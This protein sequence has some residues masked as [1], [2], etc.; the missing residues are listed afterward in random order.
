MRVTFRAFNR[1]TQKYMKTKDINLLGDGTV[2]FWNGEDW[3]LDHD[4]IL[5]IQLDVSIELP[6]HHAS[7][8]IT[9]N[10]FTT[11]YEEPEDW[12][13]GIVTHACGHEDQ[14]VEGE[15]EKAFE[16]RSI[17]EVQWYPDTPIGSYTVYASTLEKALSKAVEIQRK[18]DEVRT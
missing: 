15:M 13:Q 17:W 8:N 18:Q 3:Q 12:W 11:S 10:D 4:E 5:D 2:F 16:N 1:E 14:W 9:H 7:L 6:R